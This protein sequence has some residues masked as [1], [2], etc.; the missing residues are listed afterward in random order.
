MSKIIRI[1]SYK[2]VDEK[3]IRRISVSPRLP[4]SSEGSYW[5]PRVGRFALCEFPKFLDFNNP[6]S[7]YV[8]SDIT[9]PFV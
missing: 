2:T 4:R 8:K 9:E 7:Y 3:S 5:G 6:L 1:H